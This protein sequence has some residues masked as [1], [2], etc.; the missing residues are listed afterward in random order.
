MKKRVARRYKARFNWV[1]SSIQDRAD[2]L[3]GGKRAN[4]RTGVHMACNLCEDF[5][6]ANQVYRVRT[7]KRLAHQECINANRTKAVKKVT[8]K[9]IQQAQSKVDIQIVQELPTLD[10]QQIYLG[11]AKMIVDRVVSE[12][13]NKIVMSFPEAL[14]IQEDTKDKV[15]VS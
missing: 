6:A 11:L 8:Y 1:K 10:E 15:L 4:S 13:S 5:I 9:E 14:M 2:H 7:G 3:A 12:V